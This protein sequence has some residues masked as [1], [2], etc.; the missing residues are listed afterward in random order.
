MLRLNTKLLQSIP[1]VHHHENHATISLLNVRSIDAK[2]PDIIKDNGLKYANVLCFCETWL[3]P[4]QPSP[5]VQDDQ[6]VI[7]CDRASGD[8]KGGVMIS[9][10]EHMQPTNTHRYA[11][12]GIE[13]VSTTLLANNTSIKKRLNKG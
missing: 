5:V 6:I 1:K 9:I 12:N 4:S 3:T 10:P 8:N 2:L 7:R 13:A 11:S